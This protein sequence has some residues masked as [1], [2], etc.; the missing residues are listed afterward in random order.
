[1]MYI[2]NEGALCACSNMEVEVAVLMVAMLLGFAPV[3][4]F[5]EIQ[6]KHGFTALTCTQDL[7]T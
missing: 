2:E 1:M 6:S 7:M 5:T 3:Y 4:G